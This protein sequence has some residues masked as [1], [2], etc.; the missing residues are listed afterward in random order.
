VQSCRIVLLDWSHEQRNSLI[1]SLHWLP[2]QRRI[3]FK[4]LALVFKCLHVL[5]PDYLTNLIQISKPASPLKN[6]KDKDKWFYG[7]L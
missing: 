2:V 4:I 3:E 7:A 1:K 6:P 5:A